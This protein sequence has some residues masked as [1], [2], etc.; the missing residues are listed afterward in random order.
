MRS[1]SLLFLFLAVVLLGGSSP[2]TS[3]AAPAEPTSPKG[4]EITTVGSVP[5]VLTAAHRAKLA[6]ALRQHELRRATTPAQA[7]GPAVVLSTKPTAIE[8]REPAVGARDRSKAGQP[9]AASP[10]AVPA[11]TY[12]PAT[13]KVKPVDKAGRP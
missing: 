11:P 4:P 2:G 3:A 5:Y 9:P 8:T 7:A 13:T 6:E 1:A 12:G 10:P